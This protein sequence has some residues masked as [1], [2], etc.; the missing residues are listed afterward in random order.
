MNRIHRIEITRYGSRNWAVWLD[1]E[2]LAV[3]V[4]KKGAQAVAHALIRL[5]KP[6]GKEVHHAIL[7]A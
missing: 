6:A 3:T 1:G 2:L 5:T 4:Y 7:A